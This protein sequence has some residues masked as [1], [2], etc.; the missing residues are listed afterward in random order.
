MTTGL[1]I[2]KEHFKDYKD[3][4]IVI[5]GTACFLLMQEEGLNFRATKDI[6]IVLCVE[7]LNEEFVIHFWDFIRD[8]GYEYQHRSTGEKCFFRF[9]KPKNPNYPY[10]I[11]ILS[12]KPEILTA[13]ASGSIIPMAIGENIVSLCE[14]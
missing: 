2:F 8:G 7:A 12:Q 6:D 3:Q 9:E 13:R 10:M 11:E 14:W 4:Y 5:G 1:K